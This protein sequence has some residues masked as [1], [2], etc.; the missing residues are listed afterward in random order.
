M[1]KISPEE[2][3]A[4]RKRFLEEAAKH[5]AK[6]GFEAANINEIALSASYSKGTIYNYFKSK[7]EL[8]GEV[9]AEAAQH[10]VDHYSL[11]QR[12]TSVRSS[13]KELASADVS[14]L[15]KE[16]PFMK[17]LIG[18]AMNPQSKNYDLVITHLAPFIEA[19]SEILEEGLKRHEIR[20][21]KPTA[22]LSLVFLG[23]LTL[24]FIQHWKSE[25]IWPKLDEIPDLVVTLFLDGATKQ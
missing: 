11:T 7:E 6:Y 22:Q 13:L 17:V 19:V 20:E 4:V 2:K 21:D 14:I 25:G 8:F 15:R 1:V 24:L 16:E 12:S 10:T 18:E 9:I 23:L 5:F 3:K